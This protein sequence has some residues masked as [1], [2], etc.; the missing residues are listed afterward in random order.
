M[1]FGKRKQATPAASGNANVDKELAPEF[2]TIL[3]NINSLT[4]QLEMMMNGSK[5]QDVEVTAPSAETPAAMMQTRSKSLAKARGGP[6]K[7][8]RMKIL[9]G[10]ALS[11]EE[12][13]A[14]LDAL[15]GNA[16]DRQLPEEGMPEDEE[17][18]MLL[19]KETG[20]T[21]SEDAD[22]RIDSNQEETT[23][24]AVTEVSESV[25][26]KAIQALAKKTKP[27]VAKSAQS[28]DI[29]KSLAPIVEAVQ[30]NADAIKNLFEGLGLSESVLKSA[31]VEEPKPVQKSQG[32]TASDA[33]EL[34]REVVKA[35]RP[36]LVMPAEEEGTGLVESHAVRKSTGGTPNTR[37]GM[38][39]VLGQLALGGP[40]GRM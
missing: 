32:I 31:V 14:V 8:V 33:G 5:D 1:K 2:R 12:R 27:V 13:M 11:D 15:G 26:A 10:E 18:V 39:T 7:E 37:D 4:S 35:L 30:A 6:V 23:E 34:V 22:S 36:E 24:D 19:S 38:K 25:L 3:A 29:V 40:N 21:G 20:S 28:T 9:N 17:E 16:V